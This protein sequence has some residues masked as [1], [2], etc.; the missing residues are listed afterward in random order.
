ME[1]SDR[2]FLN[3][4]SSLENMREAKRNNENFRRLGGDPIPR[5]TAHKAEVTTTS[6]M[7]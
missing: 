3:L 6:L 1:N 5:P 4:G 2:G 7:L